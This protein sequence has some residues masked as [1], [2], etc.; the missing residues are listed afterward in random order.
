[1]NGRIDS[2]ILATIP[3]I[4]TPVSEDDAWDAFK[5]VVDADGYL[6][7]LLEYELADEDALFQ[8]YL[9]DTDLNIV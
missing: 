1:M 9:Q 2:L 7:H 6:Q 8:D 5:A 3:D 4:R